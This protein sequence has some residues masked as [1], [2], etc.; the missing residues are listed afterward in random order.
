MRHMRARANVRDGKGRLRILMKE[1]L[2][3][4]YQ[5]FSNGWRSIAM[6]AFLS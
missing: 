1:V 2:S 4:N 6:D 3:L 5:R